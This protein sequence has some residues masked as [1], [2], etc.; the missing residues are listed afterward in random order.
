MLVAALISPMASAMGSA[1]ESDSANLYASTTG[2]AQTK[3][4]KGTVVDQTGEA[5]IGVSVIVANTTIGTVTDLDGNFS[6]SGVSAKDAV[7]ISY[8]GYLPI[9]QTI[10]N[11]SLFTFTM[12]EDAKT[13]DEVVVV[14]F[15]SQKKIN[16]T[17]AVSQV[18]AD[19]LESRPVQNVSQALQGVVPGLN[20]S[21][22]SSGG[23]LNN[24]MS[25][26]IRGGGTIGDGSTS[27]PLILI[28]GMEG[29]M[30][31]INPNDIETI[32]VLKDAASAAVYGSRAP[33]GVILI[34]TKKGKSGRTSINYNNSMRFSD[35][36]LVPNMM[37]SY[38]F[39]T[40]W[41]DAATNGGQSPVFSQEM[42]ERIQA[43]QRGELKEGSTLNPNS[44]QWNQYGGANANTDWFAEH[45]KNWA[46][47][48]EHS[49][50]VNA[51]NDRVTALFSGNF[52]DTEGLLRH[53]NDNYQ[54]YSL[55]A[56]IGMKLSDWAHL[57][58]GGR[59]V[60]EDY[61]KATYQTGLFYHNIAR[62]WPV[63]PVFDPNGHY[64]E[65]SEVE[66]LKNG[67]RDKD[68]KDWMYHQI[69]LTLEPVKDWKIYLEGNMRTTNRFNHWEVLP[70]YAHD[71]DGNPYAMKWNDDY[72]PGSSRVNEYAWKENFYTTNIYTDYFKQFK[73][74]HYIKGMLGFNAETL[75]SRNLT[76]RR[77]GLISPNVP[78]LNTATENQ[79]SSGGYA[80]W[81]T[82][83]FFG[84][85]NY[86]YKERYMVEVNGRYDGSSRFIR[87]K[88][89]NFFPSFSAG[90][91]VAREAFWSPI[92]EYVSTFKFRG[93]Y[94]ILGNQNTSSLYP[95]YQTMPF[96]ASNS[97]WLI[98]GERPNTSSAPGLVSTALTWERVK[99]WNVGV[100][101]A[102]FNNRLTGSFDYF[103]RKTI[104]MVGP[105]PELPV[106]LG[107]SVP[108]VNNADM[109][110][111]GY[112]I[113]I[114][115][116]DRIGAVTYG[117][118]GVLSDSQQKVTRYPNAT[119]N[120]GQWYDGRYS[121]EIW[122]YETIG[123]AKTQEEMDAH[124]A[125]LP[126]GGQDAL[127]RNWGAGD[128]MY[129]D[130]NGD[131]KIDGGAGTLGNTGDRSVIGN[132]TARYNFG[133][134][135]D[136]QWKGLD[137]S[138][139]FQGV[140]KRDYA[141]G[142]AYFWGANGGMWQSAGF[143][144]H[145]D[146]FRPEGHVL[147]ANYD[148]YYPRPLFDGGGKNQ[149]TQTRYLQNAAYIRLK[150]VQLG[151]TIPQHIIAKAGI[152][153]LRFFVS[154]ENLWT[155][156]DLI[157][158]FDPETISGGWGEGKTYPLSKVVSFGLNVNF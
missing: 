35:P 124:L 126:N 133:L 121:G 23:E 44:N 68:Q 146:Y 58:Y 102:A 84:R 81:S 4:I 114:S 14:G 21:T 83:G 157:S 143:T 20:F 76:G 108:K 129:K 73:S 147:G 12:K 42:M 2:V 7:T 47:S 88:R 6:L 150:N 82:A 40:Y 38:S 24:S 91:N 115:W 49:L 27:S 10:G 101:F 8:I 139:F 9:T 100:D 117:V 99:S 32:S 69:Q 37:D 155:A 60:R 87:E 104:D 71:G 85:I 158:I 140:G 30:N 89:W 96:S 95:F 154:G 149:Q 137:I 48:Q 66:Q 15:G 119:N 97:S 156:T 113:E 152:Q 63:N 70:V 75:D 106:I 90:W 5:L 17:G 22:N 94:G 72:T 13:L 31:A 78:T 59:W 128:I 26:N 107:T 34:T 52:M 74:G 132:S 103:V 93:S 43:Y 41:N 62:R 109:E 120:I 127:G 51:G 141:I 105:A 18:S 151:Y 16:L 144:E 56:K 46:F 110:S 138:L 111:A 19:V 39:A 134:T 67:G 80:H 145:L 64:M 118:K 57:S 55:N 136:A 65:H 77:D 36:L 1:T 28:D 98:N 112:E 123:I 11:Q 45:Y 86:N 79:R 130:V 54:R 148:S 135:L 33:F 29:N 25:V 53:G 131:G 50:S 142:G 3:T 116:R 122:G 125:T 92:E 153:S 61:D